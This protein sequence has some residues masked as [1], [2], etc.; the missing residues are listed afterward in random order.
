MVEIFPVPDKTAAT[1]ARVLLNE[2][3]SRYGCP[4]SIHSDQGRNYESN[5]FQELC[6]LLEL[7]TTR[8]TPSHPN[9]MGTQRDLIEH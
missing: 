3:I 7:K 5:I 6:K 1:T 4:E 2:V 9:A 8:T